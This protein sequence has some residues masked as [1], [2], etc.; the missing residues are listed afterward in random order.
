M[1]VVSPSRP[2]KMQPYPPTLYR[3][4]LCHPSR[5]REMHHAGAVDD[6]HRDDTAGAA[7]APPR[8]APP[9]GAGTSAEAFAPV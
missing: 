6:T 1:V 4:F 7:D 2:R 5:P 8:N 9:A 3:Q